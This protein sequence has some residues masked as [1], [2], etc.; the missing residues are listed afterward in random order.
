MADDSQDE[1]QRAVSIAKQLLAI[2]AVS[3]RPH[4]PFTWTSGLK[5]PIYCDNRLTMIVIPRFANR[6]RKAFAAIIR[7]LY[8]D[9]KRSPA[10]RRA[11]FRMPPGWRRKLELPMLYMRDKAKGT[12]RPTRSKATT[13]PGRT[14]C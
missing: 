3:L 4:D 8:P 11:A 2:G 6:S 14:W 5:S 7:S 10:S 1:R 12:A 13:H 9:A